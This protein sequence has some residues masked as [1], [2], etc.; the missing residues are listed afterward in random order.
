MTPQQIVGTASRLFA[1]WLFITA[2]Q[3]VAI[4]GALKAGSSDPSAVWVPYLVGSFYLLAGLLSWFFPMVI[5]HKL[6]PRTKY[7]DVLRLPAQQALV[8]A[9]VVLGLLVIAFKALAPVMGYLSVCALWIGSGQTI[10][11]MDADRHIDG[12]IGFAQLAF[13]LF[14]VLKAHVVARRLL[15]EPRAPQHEIGGEVS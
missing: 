13:G 11:T 15:E 4:G 3:A 6:V 12:F 1:I 5:A 7:D 14:L 2:F 8:V 9:C 10:S